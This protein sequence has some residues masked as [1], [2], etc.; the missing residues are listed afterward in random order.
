MAA[1]AGI[2]PRDAL[3]LASPGTV[4]EAVSIKIQQKTGKRSD[5]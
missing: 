4:F 2:P 1:F 3:L 5:D